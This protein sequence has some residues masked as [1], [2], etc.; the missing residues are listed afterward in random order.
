MFAGSEIEAD[1]SQLGYHPH[2][3]GPGIRLYIIILIFMVVL[4]HTE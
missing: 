4:L 2:F 1:L 3:K